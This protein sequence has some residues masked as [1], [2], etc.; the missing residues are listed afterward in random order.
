MPLVR[1]LTKVNSDAALSPA[2]VAV[3]Q[4]ASCVVIADNSWRAVLMP[5]A[6]KSI[7]ANVWYLG[8]AVMASIPPTAERAD[9]AA[10]RTRAS[11]AFPNARKK[12]QLSRDG[13]PARRKDAPP[14]ICAVAARIG[15]WFNVVE[16]WIYYLPL[17]EL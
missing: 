16:A 13:G 12:R 9:D 4:D 7:S 14:S 6:L 15:L 17:N 2:E 3:R 11:L 1:D 8:W 10:D 5:T